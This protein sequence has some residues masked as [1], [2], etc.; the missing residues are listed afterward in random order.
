[1][2]KLLEELGLSEKEAKVYLAALELGEESV[3]NI[4]KK[5][6]VNRATT[7]VILNKLMGLGLVSTYEND[8]KTV[9]VAQDPKELLNLIEREEK[10]IGQRKRD[11]QD[12]LNQ[13]NAIFNVN[14]SKPIVRFFEG[15]DGLEALD[16]YGRTNVNT[17]VLS[18]SPIDLIEKYFP[19]RRKKSLDE[20]IK[21]GIKVKTI[22]THEG[23]EISEY[24]NQDELREGIYISRDKFP[25][26]AT[27]N[28]YPNWGIKLYYFN[29]EHPYGVVIESKE[30]AKNM[31]LLY[32]L[33]WKGA[34]K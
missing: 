17:E 24:Q 23:G 2:E 16:R 20:R 4:G 29:E 5:A 11:L 7:Y 22:Y 25:L 32:E 19:D 12:N 15:I 9:F 10:E 28:I 14:K 6:G 21:A 13:L 3:Q 26:D 31:A 30:L 34:K 8:K 1:M 18:V 33:A 27:I